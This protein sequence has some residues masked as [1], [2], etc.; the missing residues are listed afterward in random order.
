MLGCSGAARSSHHTEGNDLG[1]R[2]TKER[3]KFLCPVCNCQ[4]PAGAFPKHLSGVHLPLSDPSPGPSC[5][6]DRIQSPEDLPCCLFLVSPSALLI[7]SLHRGQSSSFRE[8]AATCPHVNWP[9]HLIAAVWFC[10]L[11]CLCQLPFVFEAQLSQH[12]QKAF[13]GFP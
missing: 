8:P 2:K 9:L 7:L 5:S 4:Q 3:S 13:P 6:Q 11:A 10:C 12:F 1:R